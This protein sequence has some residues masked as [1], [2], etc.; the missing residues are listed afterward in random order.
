M[1]DNSVKR[2][3]NSSKLKVFMLLFS[4]FTIHYSLFPKDVIAQAISL[5]ITPPLLELTIQ[6]GKEVKQ[7]YSITNNG[8]DT[9]LTPKIVYFTSA[10]ESGNI[11]LSED[12][13]PDWIKYNKDPINL[14]NGIKT[15]YNVIFSPPNN[16]EEIDHF[17][18]LIFESTTPVDLINQNSVSY[19]SQI[20]TNIL[21]TISK[22]GNPKKSAEIIEF[23]AP[24]IIDS[25][26][27]ISYPGGTSS[28]YHL[29]LANNGNSFWKPI[30]KIITKGET[31]KL[32]PQNILSGSNRIISCIQDENLINCNFKNKFRIGKIV[33]N[34][35]FTTDDD[36]KIYKKEV[37]TIAFPFSIFGI[38]FLILTLFRRRGILNLWRKRK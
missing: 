28:A 12:S 18:T 21:L 23:S 38:I 19:Q 1:Q 8:G 35:E 16:T 13:A 2:K 24:R 15:D 10:D 6:P 33:S 7:T 31:L 5:S 4:L 27:P 22:D 17:L 29:I 9:V 20:G 14:K 11:D 36:P 37:T 34:L 25:I 32:A 30:G 3:A 26:L